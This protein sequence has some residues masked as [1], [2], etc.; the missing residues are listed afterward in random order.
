MACRLLGAKPLPE[1]MLVFIVNWTLRNK[2]QWNTDQ[3][4][5]FVIDK[6]ALEMEKMS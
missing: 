4:T 1:P 3:N 2:I 5:K 6:N